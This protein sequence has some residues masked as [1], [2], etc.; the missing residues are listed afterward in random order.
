M[1]GSVKLCFQPAEEGHNGA[2]PMIQ[3]GIL[4]GNSGAEATK[5]GGPKVD[6]VYGIHLW[7]YAKFGV[8]QV[9]C[10]SCLYF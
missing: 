3:D 7:T 8:V 4:E 6:F 1:K 5:C 10:R 2:E 9:G